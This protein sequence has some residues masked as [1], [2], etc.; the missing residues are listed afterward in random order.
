MLRDPGQAIY[1]RRQMTEYQELEEGPSDA[2]P[3]ELAK[4][5]TRLVTESRSEDANDEEPEADHPQQ[6]FRTESSQGVRKVQAR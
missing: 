5:T 6:S 2:M 3:A 4:A 1:G